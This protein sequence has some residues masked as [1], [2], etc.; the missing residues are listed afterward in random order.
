MLQ[1]SSPSPETSDLE[2][3]MVEL[4]ES[5]RKLVNLKMQKDAAVGIHMPAPSAVNGNLSPEKTADRSKRLRELRDSLDETKILAAD[6]LSELEDARDE[7][8]TLS[9]E[10][11]DLENE[12]KDDKH[13]YSSRLYSLVDDQLQHWND[14]V[15][16]YKTLTDSL[17]VI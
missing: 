9:K 14:E 12:L 2:E 8:Q 17:Q 16:R 13:I 5:R 3:I 7:N 1:A 15:E 4:E 10:L 6:R 11:E